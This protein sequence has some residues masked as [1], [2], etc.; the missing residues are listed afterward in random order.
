[1]INHVCGF[2]SLV[3]LNLKCKDLIFLENKI[4]RTE[5]WFD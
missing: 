2:M 4:L 1:M 5:E 3:S